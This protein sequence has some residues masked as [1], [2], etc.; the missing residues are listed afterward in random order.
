MATGVT[1]DIKE[2]LQAGDN[3]GWE[4]ADKIRRALSNSQY[5]ELKQE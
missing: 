4:Q 3:F 1:I 5:A 2:A